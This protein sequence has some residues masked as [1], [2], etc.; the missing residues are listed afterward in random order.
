MGPRPLCR[1]GLLLYLLVRNSEKDWSKY[2]ARYSKARFGVQIQF[3]DD[4]PPV[5]KNRPGRIELHHLDNGR[6]RA[7][8]V[9]TGRKLFVIAKPQHRPRRLLSENRRKRL[10]WGGA[11]KIPGTD[12]QYLE[13]DEP[14]KVTNPFKWVDL[15]WFKMDG[16]YVRP[17]NQPYVY[18]IP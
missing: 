11:Q 4:F 10:R 18:G 3:L 8:T 5:A 6:L 1:P 14:D 2:W 17:K 7:L 13:F 16:K 15:T 12:Y 9:Q